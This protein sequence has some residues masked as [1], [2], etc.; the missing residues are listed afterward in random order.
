MNYISRLATK[1]IRGENKN[2]LIGLTIIF[3]A[4]ILSLTLSF[5]ASNQIG[6]HKTTKYMPQ[7]TVLNKSDKINDI[8]SDRSIDKI[9]T[10]N[11]IDQVKFQGS[12]TNVIYL[13]NN[14]YFDSIK[15]ELPID[16]HD[17]MIEKSISDKYGLK[18]GDEIK[19]DDNSGEKTFTISSIAYR[20]MEVS[21]ANLYVSENYFKNSKVK[22][23]SS[24]IFLK[25]K[26]EKFA[27]SKANEIRDKF[28]IPKEN[29]NIYN[30][31]FTYSNNQKISDSSIELTLILLLLSIT[32]SLVLYSIYYISINRSINELG[33]LRALGLKRKDL[34]N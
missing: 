1:Y 27:Y 24:M 2:F 8:K 7:I 34:K 23:S 13:D 15:G 12:P 5:S 18:I 25:D 29:I 14:N 32:T 17:I 9:V 19:V 10:L 3:S 21:Q 31:F 26:S 4:F 11:I 6:I 16:S 28:E 30:E 22:V 33:K 20:D